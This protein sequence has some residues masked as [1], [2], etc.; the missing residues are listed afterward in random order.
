M[1]A[2]VA[3]PEDEVVLA[4][5]DSVTR[6]IRVRNTG[7]VVDRFELDVLGDAAQWTTVAPTSVNLLPGEERAVQLVFA[8]PRTPKVTAGIVPFAVRVMSCEDTAGSVISEAAVSVSAF[9]TLAAEL[10]PRTSRGSRVGRHQLAVDNL[11]NTPAEIRILPSDPDAQLDFRVTP[12]TL[13]AAPGTATFLKVRASPRKRFLKGADKTLPFEITVLAPDTDPITVPGSV[14]QQPLV[15]PWLLKVVLLAVVALVGFA[16]LWQTMLKPEV[17]S[18]ARQ[19][20][21]EQTAPLK[22]AV[23]AS[24]RTANAAA[25]NA[26]EARVAAGLP[27]KPVPSADPLGIDSLTGAPLPGDPAAGDPAAA[28]PAGT[29]E[30][31]TAGVDAPPAAGGVTNS[32]AT[33]F[34]ITTNAPPGN[35]GEFVPFAFTP[36]KDKLVWI[37][38]IV[39]QNPRGDSG[40]LQ[41][42]RG[43]TVLLEFGLENFR[44]LDYHLL[45]PVRFSADEPVV[46]AVDCRNAGSAACTPSVY[47]TGRTS[48]EPAPAKSGG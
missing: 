26:E 14:L 43:K 16:I 25:A 4:P 33:D 48:A 20:T 42:R 11:G 9:T 10:L 46:I 32:S 23:A 3:L 35:P 18:T 6:E 17:R 44:D 39:L 21:E 27:P 28:D 36:P 1:G 29:G 2:S 12:D 8:P 7:V 34:R 31:T 13:S 37:S 38:D 30:V 22:T 5:G 40:I 24:Q 15:P 45:Q 19:V 47:F 41:I